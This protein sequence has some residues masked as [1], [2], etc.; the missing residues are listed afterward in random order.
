MIFFEATVLKKYD[1][2]LRQYEPE[3]L[4]DVRQSLRASG[5]GV[6]AIQTFHYLAHV[7]Y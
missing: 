1:F 7:F 5:G 4:V 3:I 6:V 2:K